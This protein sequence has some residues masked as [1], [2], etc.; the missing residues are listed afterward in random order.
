MAMKGRPKTGL[1]NVS[2]VPRAKA[3][4]GSQ[5]EIGEKQ[6]TDLENLQGQLSVDHKDQNKKG[7]EAGEGHIPKHLSSGKDDTHVSQVNGS[8][9][10]L[11]RRTQ[12]W[13]IKLR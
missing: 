3:G 4:E 8:L 6:R 11:H 5:E 9:D 1:D 10:S 13:N 7:G 2:A 12:I